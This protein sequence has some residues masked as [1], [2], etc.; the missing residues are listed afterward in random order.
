MTD[1]EYKSILLP[2]YRQMYATAFA[3][4][5]D[6][7]DASDVVQDMMILLWQK[8]EAIA[9]PQ[10]PQAF[11]AR[12]V[13][14]HCIDRLRSDT[15]RYFERIDSLY[16]MTSDIATDTDVSLRM[17]ESYISEI[18]STFKAKQRKIL[19]LSI[20]SQLSN[21]EISSITG[22]SPENVRVI[23]SRGRKKIREYMTDER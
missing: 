4:L 20:F 13:R 15:G 21:D 11:C 17:T 2:C 1:G 10:N 7:A 3:I 16:G 12:L 22:E 9:I 23:L 5:H 19:I 6:S 14:N 8:H 18:L